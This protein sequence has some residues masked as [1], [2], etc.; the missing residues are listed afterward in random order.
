MIKPY[1]LL[2]WGNIYKFHALWSSYLS[3]YYNI[4]FK[5]DRTSGAIFKEY[6][7]WINTCLAKK[8]Y[9]SC[10]YI[11]EIWCVSN[12]SLRIIRI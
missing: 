9:T 5:K 4:N 2:I 3:R 12:S 1:I 6:I 8:L 7:T 10:V 11:I